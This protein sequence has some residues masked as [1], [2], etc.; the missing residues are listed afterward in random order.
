MITD[1][2]PE[3]SGLGI[4]TQKIKIITVP[5]NNISVKSKRED[6][7]QRKQLRTELGT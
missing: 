7:C 3:F 5:I 2:L 1:K 4:L 6:T